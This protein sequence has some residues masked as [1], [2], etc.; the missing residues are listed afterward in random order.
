MNICFLCDEYPPAVNGG[1]GR[2]IQTTARALVDKG[3]TARVI[4][5]YAPNCK[6]QAYEKDEGVE[7][8]R[9]FPQ[10][11]FRTHS[12]RCDHWLNFAYLR[13]SV[14]RRVAEWARRG[15]VDLVEAPD[16]QGAVAGWPKL[17]VPVVVRLHGSETF[18]MPLLKQN[19][20][21]SIHWIE[22]KGLE[23]ADFL[24]APSAYAAT[25]SQRA[26]RAEPK[27]CAVL[28][29][30]SPVPHWRPRIRERWRVVYNG[31]LAER[32]GVIQ[33]IK[34]WPHVQRDCP[35]AELHLY[36][37]NTMRLDGGSMQDHLI[38]LLP[39]NCRER[40]IFH[41]HVPRPDLDTAIAAAR[42]CVFP[43]LSEA[44]GL[45]PVDAMAAGCPTIFGKACAGPEIIEHGRSGLLV[46]GLKPEE[47]SAAIL[48][49]LRE[50]KFADSCA[51]AGWQR[52]RDLFSVEAL[53]PRFEAHYAECI[54]D[55]GSR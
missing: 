55:F 8:Y 6:L 36:G 32:K 4:G 7:V 48:R 51:H 20:R 25:A 10:F 54:R 53:V 46:D 44:F 49:F 52:A 38:N 27:S 21:Q 45:A 22:S 23:R 2:V 17:P 47:I 1:I 31:T 37:K 42:T 12:R 40:V 5:A 11:P 35:D 13:H 33:L 14:Y 29:N 30:M 19:P 50:D 43:S 39:S 3:H 18:L 16:Y 41:G 15:E 28:Y 9:V 34:S 26:F 24:N